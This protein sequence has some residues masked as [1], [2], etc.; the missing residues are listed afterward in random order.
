M[1]GDRHMQG[2]LAR[3]VAGALAALGV[4]LVAATAAVA[5]DPEVESENFA[6]TAEREQ[7][8][9]KTPAFQT[10][11][12]EKE[13]ESQ[14]ENV[15]IQTTDPE[16]NPYGNVC[17]SRQRECAG[18]VRFYDWAEDTDGIR[19]PVL[20]TARSGATL[21]GNV[22][23]TRNGPARRPAV[24]ITTGSV[25]APET[26]Y[27]GTAAM[28]ARNGY[29]VLTYDVQGQ[30]RSD[31]FGAG[32][33]SQ[34]S[35]PSQAGQPFFDGPEDALDFMLSS[36]GDRYDPRPSCG[37]AAGG[38]GTDHSNKHNRRVRD[39]FNAPFNPLHRLIDRSRVGI[40]GHSLGAAGV[41]YV[42]QLDRRVDAIV[43]WDNLGDVS[44]PEGSR[45]GVPDCPSKSSRRP[46]TLKLTKPALGFSNDYGITPTPNTSDPDPQRANQGF[47]G[48]KGAGV[49]SMQINI[50]GGTHEEYAF[51]P[52]Q[53]VPILGLA[54]YRGMDLQSWYTRAWLDRFVKCA[55]AAA[56]KR[57][58]EKRLLTDRWR[59]DGPGK[60]VDTRDDGNL[61][62]FYL[63]SRYAF[64]TVDGR[65]ARCPDM[66]K[67]CRLMRPDG[68]E[69]N[70]YFQIRDAYERGA[71]G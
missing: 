11:L 56:C 19:K 43:A 17:W 35:V 9:T 22:W 26:L 47:L 58:A 50:R 71:T 37:N 28:L 70:N 6:K 27:W 18:D 21:S 59:S 16:R 23:A 51:I 1:D 44:D 4:C 67:G 31:T 66:R 36:P 29:V 14:L 62:S 3:R 2:R 25:Q 5:F 12:A 61:F 24:V 68:L 69:P 45:F 33:D 60:R 53:T 65:R 39:G 42:G 32:P 63:R 15:E 57:R 48:Y 30:G 64:D 13:A 8:I 46:E 10:L 54:T 20:F 38:V 41:S 34:E 49:D 7:Y 52:G 40:T 55:D